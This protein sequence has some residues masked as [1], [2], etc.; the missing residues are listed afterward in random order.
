MKKQKE[1]HQENK[2]YTQFF[3]SLSSAFFS[4]QNSQRNSKTPLRSVL[5]RLWPFGCVLFYLKSNM[6]SSGAKG[7]FQ[8]RNRSAL[9]GP[10]RKYFD[11]KSPCSF[12]AE[13]SFWPENITFW[14]KRFMQFFSSKIFVVLVA[15]SLLHFHPN[16]PKMLQKS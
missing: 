14:V 16:I 12:L 1:N 13:S 10:K 9:Y 2:S 8:E 3:I 5:G 11:P 4:I 7:C 6:E 15:S